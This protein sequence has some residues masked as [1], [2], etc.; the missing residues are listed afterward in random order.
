VIVTKNCGVRTKGQEIP[1]RNP[2]ESTSVRKTPRRNPG[3]ESTSGQKTPRR[4][5]GELTSGQETPDQ[6]PDE[7]TN[8]Q[9]TPRRMPGVPMTDQETEHREWLRC[10]DGTT[11][12]ARAATRAQALNGTP[13]RCLAESILPG[14]DRGRQEAAG[15]VLRHP[16]EIGWTIERARD[17]AVTVGTVP[18]PAALQAIELRPTTRIAPVGVPTAAADTKGGV[19]VAPEKTIAA[20]TETETGIVTEIVAATTAALSPRRLWIPETETV[21]PRTETFPGAVSHPLRRDHPIP[22]ETTAAATART[23]AAGRGLLRC[24]AAATAARSPRTV[25]RGRGSPGTEG[26]DEGGSRPATTATGAAKRGCLFGRCHIRVLWCAR[27]S[28]CTSYGS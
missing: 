14:T 6:R 8:D 20:T 4:N 22:V 1:H 21:L 10:L 17:G 5:L 3:K 23:P 25:L 28:S 26:T 12:A 11:I 16:A 2:D 18:G 9:E 15:A 24:A 7:S 27:F 13:Q 19:D